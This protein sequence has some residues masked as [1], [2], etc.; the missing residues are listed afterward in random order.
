MSWTWGEFGKSS[1][2]WLSWTL[3]E[4]GKSSVKWL[5]WT[6]C[7]FDKSS[8]DLDIRTLK[9]D[10]LTEPRGL[11]YC[12]GPP[13]AII[14]TSL[15]CFECHQNVWKWNLQQIDFDDSCPNSLYVYL[16]AGVTVQ[17]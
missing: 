7:E 3:C 8:E 14:V 6:L 13:Y 16:Y 9:V 2:K 4:F 15:S 5:S 1:V 17:V 12:S 10:S 11:L